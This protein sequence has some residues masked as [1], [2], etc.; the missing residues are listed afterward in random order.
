MDFI[1][2]LETIGYPDTEDWDGAIGDFSQ[3]CRGLI[4]DIDLAFSPQ[5][6]QSS[7]HVLLSP[8]GGNNG[9]GDF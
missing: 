8:I 7:A 3:F 2:N 4:R 6:T 1:N 5:L 9:G